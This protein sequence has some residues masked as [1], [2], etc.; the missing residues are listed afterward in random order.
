M[1]DFSLADVNWEY[2]ITETSRSRRFLKHLDGY[3]LMQILR[4]LTR[5]GQLLPF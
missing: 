1:G 3:F 5:K 4:E 2:H